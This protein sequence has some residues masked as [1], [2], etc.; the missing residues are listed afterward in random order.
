MI[1]QKI[2]RIK[3]EPKVF[4]S[5]E[6]GVDDISIQSYN[7]ATG[8][9]FPDRTVSPKILTPIIG[10]VIKTTGERLDNAA[11]LL[12]DG[13]WYRLDSSTSGGLTSGTE[14]DASAPQVTAPD[15]TKYDR[16][17]IDTTLGSATY[18]QIIIR[19][20]VHPD[21]P[22]TYI[23]TATLNVGTPRRIKVSFQA[24]TNAVVV[25]PEL[26]FDNSMQ[27]HYN[28]WEDPQFFSVTPKVVPDTYPATYKWQAF[29]DS[30]WAD[31]GQSHYDWAMKVD[32]ATGKLTIDRKVMQDHLI[33]K[34]VATVNVNG[35]NVVIERAGSHTRQLPGF[36]TYIRENGEIL[37]DA[38]SIQRSVNIKT[39]KGD[40]T[41]LSE[42]DISWYGNNNAKIAS[43]S[44]ATINIA[45]LG[46]AMELGLDVVDRGGWCSAELDN[47]DWL[48]DND[49]KILLIR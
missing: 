7:T 37:A 25:I 3:S 31:V 36:E 24:R 43:G 26:M 39:A 48:I 23:F 16:Y 5:M 27:S 46:A 40:I 29:H 42:L 38:K 9:Y 44:P 15:G 13:H 28:P 10:Y 4:A 2:N 1:T 33:F 8:Q 49:G 14:I 12:T 47:G 20:N 34:C 30:T 11:K 35:K 22:V 19:E 21:N 41:D 32:A 6:T 17:E 45:S 18:G